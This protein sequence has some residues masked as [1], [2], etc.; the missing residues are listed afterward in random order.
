MRFREGSLMRPLEELTEARLQALEGVIFDVDD[1]LTTHGLLHVE[2]LDALWALHRAGLRLI[3]STGR[4]LGWTDVMASMWP[5][6]LA[7]GENGAGWSRREGGALAVGYFDEEA[8]RASYPARL[9]DVREAVSR[10]LPD[11]CIATDQ[12]A[13]RCDL[14]FDVG[15]KQTLSAERVAQLV[16][17]I[18]SR[19][20]RAFVS[21]VHAHVIVGDWDKASGVR[22]AA[23]DALEIDIDTSLWLFVGD[24]G[25]D[26]AAFQAFELTVGVANVRDHLDRLS[27]PPRW[28]TREARGAGFAELAR[29]LLSARGA[30]I[31]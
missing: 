15:E 2:A 22:R 9:D 14:A 17:V 18:E 26:A 11:V 19:G 6:D 8:V 3:A 29:H 5:I 20:A 27:T 23:L 21:S 12:P 13:R 4:P 24:S 16:G 28:V 7:V 1:T 25:N 31:G 10:E 30:R